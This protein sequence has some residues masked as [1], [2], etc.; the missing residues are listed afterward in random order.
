MDQLMES[1]DDERCSISEAL[2]AAECV[3]KGI[4]DPDLSSDSM[5]RIAEMIG[6]V[7]SENES[8]PYSEHEMSQFM[9]W[10]ESVEE[11]TLNKMYHDEIC[12]SLLVQHDRVRNL[13]AFDR[14]NAVFQNVE[15]MEC[16]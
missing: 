16:H 9:R 13:Y 15:S 11:V 5:L 2:R 4:Y 10:T 14:L 8:A 3:I 12:E 1:V 6:I 7:L